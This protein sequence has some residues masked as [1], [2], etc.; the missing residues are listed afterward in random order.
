MLAVQQLAARWL[1][2]RFR[3]LATVMIVNR[4]VVWVA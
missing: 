2:R 1:C 4:E 3:K